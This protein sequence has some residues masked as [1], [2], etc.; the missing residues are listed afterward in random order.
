M[1]T[2]QLGALQQL[3]DPHRYHSCPRDGLTKVRF[4]SRTVTAVVIVEFTPVVGFGRV[5]VYGTLMSERWPW[6]ETLL[7]L[8]SMAQA[9]SRAGLKKR[10]RPPPSITQPVVR[11]WP[12]MDPST[13]SEMPHRRNKSI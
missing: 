11:T 4:S 10:L 8:R 12:K 5:R 7:M 9:L 3:A 1:P 6:L 13:G 2:R